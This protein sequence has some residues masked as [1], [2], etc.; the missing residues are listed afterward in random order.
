MVYLYI[1]YLC[2]VFSNNLLQNHFNIYLT[3]I[4]GVTYLIYL[5]GYMASS[6]FAGETIVESELRRTRVHCLSMQHLFLSALYRFHIS[7]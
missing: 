1:I 5:Y 3:F 6:G 7:S 2:K 4:S